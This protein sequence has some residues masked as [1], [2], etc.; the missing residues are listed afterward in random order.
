MQYQRN[1]RE[2]ELGPCEGVACGSGQEVH[3]SPK[4]FGSPS[5]GHSVQLRGA[6]RERDRP[7]ARACREPSVL[8]QALRMGHLTSMEI[9]AT[10]GK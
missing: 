5:A 10:A 1:D 6:K 3:S 8:V 2:P 9:S 4:A 7:P